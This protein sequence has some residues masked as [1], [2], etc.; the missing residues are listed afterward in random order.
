MNDVLD[1]LSLT[2]NEELNATITLQGNTF[3]IKL[4]DGQKVK[5]TVGVA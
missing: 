4:A 5:I 2:L 3:F 1:V